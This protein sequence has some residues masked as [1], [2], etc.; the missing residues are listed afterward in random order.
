MSDR[1]TRGSPEP[2]AMSK[3]SSRRGLWIAIGG[4]VALLA[5]GVWLVFA[6]LPSFLTRSPEEP[7]AP[8]GAGP[9]APAGESRKIQATLFYV[10]EDGAELVPVNREVVYGPNPAEQARHIVEAQVAA[11]PSGLVSA[12]PAGTTV[13]AVFL[14]GRGEAYVD[15]SPEAATAHSGG[16][17][18]EALAIFAIVNALTANLADVTA[19]QILIDGKEVDTLA[20]HVDLRQPLAQ[21]QKW[22]RKAQ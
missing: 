20:G 11:A 4:G 13:R 3:P 21:G 12:I 2:S 14:A 18:N 1:L 19:V 9:S 22:V 5:A 16:S 15:L 10:S 7:A 8:P 17:L 6:M